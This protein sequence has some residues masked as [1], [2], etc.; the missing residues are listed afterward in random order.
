MDERIR[1]ATK[2]PY[3]YNSS[4]WTSYDN[5]QSVLIKAEYYAINQG[6]AGVMVWSV[7]FDENICGAGANPLLNSITGKTTFF[8]HLIILE[9]NWTKR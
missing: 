4:K 3:F 7:D 5:P 6:L 1:H 8:I 9:D 2:V